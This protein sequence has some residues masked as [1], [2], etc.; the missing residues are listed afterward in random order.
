M[1]DEK[2]L[3]FPHQMQQLNILPQQLSCLIIQTR[4]LFFYPHQNIGGV[5]FEITEKCPSAAPSEE[6]RATKWQ[7]LK[8]RQE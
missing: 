7:I 5:S 3:F 4:E 6:I 2:K 1:F 8:A